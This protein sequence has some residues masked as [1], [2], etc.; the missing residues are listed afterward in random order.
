MPP[1]ERGQRVAIWIGVIVAAMI[2]FGLLA[3]QDWVWATLFAVAGSTLLA[4][5]V[6]QPLRR[7]IQRAVDRRFDRARVDAE[8]IAAAFAERLRSEVAIDAV[9]DDL[10]ATV[11]TALRPSAQGLWLRRADG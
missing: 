8:R 5:A 6:F 3:S 9:A 2:G 7:R 10:S 1:G 11:G 4:F